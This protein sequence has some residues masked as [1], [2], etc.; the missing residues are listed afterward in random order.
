MKTF[1]QFEIALLFLVTIILSLISAFMFHIQIIAGI[2]F[3]IAGL[4]Y[5]LCCFLVIVKTDIHDDRLIA[6]KLLGKKN[7]PF[8]NV[9]GLTVEN[10]HFIGEGRY[11]TRKALVIAY[12]EVSGYK[13]ELVLTYNNDL[14]HYLG[15]KL[16]HVYER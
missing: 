3:L 1:Y 12:I 6:Y 8:K 16:G 4:F 2:V 14:H 9:N 13:D 11:S 10:R 15:E 5:L 7:I